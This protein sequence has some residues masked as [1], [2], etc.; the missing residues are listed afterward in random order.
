MEKD[1][2]KP[3]PEGEARHRRGGRRREMMVADEAC[4]DVQVSIPP[5]MLAWARLEAANQGHASLSAYLRALIT[6]AMERPDTD[7][8]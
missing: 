8:P 2:D 4:K 1:N 7:A 5:A 3:S 6:Q